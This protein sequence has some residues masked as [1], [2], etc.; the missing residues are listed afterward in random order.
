MA[1]LSFVYGGLGVA[2]SI[3]GGALIFLGIA[4]INQ[5]A[6]KDKAA[7]A[8]KDMV[9]SFRQQL[10]GVITFLI[11]SLVVS[12]ILDAMVIIAGIGLMRMRNW[13]RYLAIFCAVA[14]LL[15]H[16]GSTAYSMAVVGPATEEWQ[17]DFAKKHPELK[18]GENPF[19]SNPLMNNI[20][21]VAQTAT[22]VAF[23]VALLV[24]MLLPS[25]SAAFR[26]RP[27]GDAAGLSDE[28][29]DEDYER[30]K[31]WGD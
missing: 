17:K 22:S 1:I 21:A 30:N 25:V 10:P 20:S 23:A 3:C 11:V 6:A 26:G 4:L 19:G 12:A 16:I 15:L 14:M 24:V 31:G 28:G 29:Y 18:A 9:E 2:C 5:A 13:G 7:Q 27:A 8:V